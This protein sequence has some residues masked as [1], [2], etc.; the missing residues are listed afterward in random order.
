[1]AWHVQERTSITGHGQASTFVSKYLEDLKVTL[2]RLRT[3][4]RCC[5]FP[6]TLTSFFSIS[7]PQQV[8]VIYLAFCKV[9]GAPGSSYEMNIDTFSR[10]SNIVNNVAFSRKALLPNHD[11]FDVGSFFWLRLLYWRKMLATAGVHYGTPWW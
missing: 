1:M 2:E 11:I 7:I 10:R 4:K 8:V 5:T 3:A 9:P 6:N